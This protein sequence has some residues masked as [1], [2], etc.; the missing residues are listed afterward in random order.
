MGTLVLLS[1]CSLADRFSPPPTRPPAQWSNPAAAPAAW[2]SADWW[3]QFGSARLDQLMADAQAANFDIAAAI[4][5]VRQADAQARVAG[6]PLLPSVQAD[7]SF[8]R[9]RGPWVSTSSTS[10]SSRT[11]KA[12]I[13]NSYDG[14]LS[15]SY[16]IDFWG[17]NRAALEAAEAAAQASRF[18]QQTVALTVQSSVATTYFDV[19]GGL[20]RIRVA[21]DNIA[22]GEGVLEAIRDRVAAGTATAL[23]LAQQE[24]VVAAQRATIA[25]L[26]QQWRQNVNALAILTGRQPDQ[27][28]LNPE[29]LAQ[30]GIPA[31]APGLPSELLVR[32]P[33]VQFAE[34]QLQ[35]AN[36]D[37]GAARAAF[38]PSIS[39]TAEGGFTSSALATLIDH[40]SLFTSL[41]NSITQPIFQG[42]KLEGNL[43]QKKARYD[44]LVANYRK[45][46]AQAFSDVE[47]GL[48]A[49]EQTAAEEAAQREAERTARN[50]YD[51]AQS[52]FRAGIIDITTLLNT[53]SR[54]FTA[55]DNLAQARLAHLQATVT[56]YKA[57]GGGW[58]AAR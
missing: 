32:R 27:M 12:P 5:R 6:A 11:G 23:D 31:V 14:T 49:V 1:A 10:T 34:A 56:L 7:G 54:L 13:T 3:R 57:M 43:E 21:A 29:K 58:T 46:V 17:K 39:L 53:Q 2:P 15:A 55:E 24:S 16:E 20:E 8:K 38:F 44:E 36:A 42:G 25:P 26:E 22:N 51:I 47:N 41:A 48:I 35:G 18:D 19:L 50:A 4:A 28:S 40:K 30:L 52:Q 9:Q 45:A 33:D 37:I